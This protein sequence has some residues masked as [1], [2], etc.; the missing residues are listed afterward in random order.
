[1]LSDLRRLTQSNMAEE[2]ERFTAALQDDLVL[3]EDF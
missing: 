1:M 2:I 3:P